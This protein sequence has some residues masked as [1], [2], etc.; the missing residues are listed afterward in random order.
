[1]ENK[2]YFHLTYN[3]YTIYRVLKVSKILFETIASN[4]YYC[5]DL[6][7][8]YAQNIIHISYINGIS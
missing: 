4:N 1:M 8:I 7:Q 6:V 3:Y 2:L 5:I